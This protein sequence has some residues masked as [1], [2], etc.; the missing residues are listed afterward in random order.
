MIENKEL[1]NGLELLLLCYLTIETME[2]YNVKGL[3]KKYLNLFRNQI[4][5]KVVRRIDEIHEN[6][7]EF[8]NQCLKSK[9]RM[10]NQI[11]SLNEAD[12]ILF[13]DFVDKYINNIELA[14]KKGLIF[15]DK[16]L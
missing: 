16:L 3:E 1:K 5:K 8:F 15:F 6:N 9:N 11:A 12:Q 4:E 14:R 7:E 13:S 10:I 2:Q